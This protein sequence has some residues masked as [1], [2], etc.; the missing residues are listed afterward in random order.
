MTIICP[1]RSPSPKLKN[2][3]QRLWHLISMQKQDMHTK[4]GPERKRDVAQKTENSPRDAGFLSRRYVITRSFHLGFT[5]SDS[6]SCGVEGKGKEAGVGGRIS[7]WDGTSGARTGLWN[8]SP[9]TF[10]REV[11]HREARLTRD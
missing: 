9:K 6:P 11:S 10:P 8:I 2:W 7:E 3:F 4:E 5:Q 1:S